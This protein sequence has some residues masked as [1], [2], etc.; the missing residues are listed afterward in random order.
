MFLYFLFSR[1][2]AFIKSFSSKLLSVVHKE[3]IFKI[4][5]FYTGLVTR[6]FHDKIC[7]ITSIWKGSTL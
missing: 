7:I 6:L 2:L 3:A 4:P 5:F 1:P